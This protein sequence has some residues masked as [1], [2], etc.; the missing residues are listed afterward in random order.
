M[1]KRDWNL[2][3]LV[4]RQN[5]DGS[6]RRYWH[7][8]EARVRLPDPRRPGDTG[9][10]A[11]ITELNKDFDA[12]KS[13]TVF[14]YGSWLW[15]IEDFKKTDRYKGLAKKTRSIYDRW[16]TDLTKR[17]ER[18]NNPSI[19]SID[20][21]YCVDYID[22]LSGASTKR[23]AAAV[24][25]NIMDRALYHGIVKE[26]PANKL[27][28]PTGK[29]RKHLILDNDVKRFLKACKG[30]K[31]EDTLIIGTQLLRYTG[32]RPGDLLRAPKS[33]ISEVTDLK[34]KKKRLVL[35]LV[36]QKTGTAV[37]I[38]IHKSLRPYVERALKIEG[39]TLIPWSGR[40]PLTRAY[41]QNFC[42]AVRKKIGLGSAQNRDYRPFAVTKLH[43]AGCSESHIA[44]V[45]GHSIASVREIMQRH[46]LIQTL[47]GAEVG[48]EK[49]EE[50]EVTDRRTERG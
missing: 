14:P 23:Q 29:G 30:H 36:Q 49:W 6:I 13:Q 34:T 9:W 21:K 28:V 43:E 45:T 25:Q 16:L 15:A 46:Y 35:S 37:E 32:Q 22:A 50:M 3:G 31:H 10:C 20:R 12:R 17:G 18:L 8:G 40:N 27:R 39:D 24:L 5:K 11:F 33:A 47:K 38:P 7:R 4:T 19:K 44:S 42:A 1:P 26:N 2:T 48:I 41:F